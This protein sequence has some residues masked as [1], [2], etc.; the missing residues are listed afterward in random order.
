MANDRHYMVMDTE[1][2]GLYP[3]KGHE[4]VQLC[5]TAVNCYTLE[6]H[7][8]G[9]FS[10]LIKPQN[11]DKAD[12]KAIEV[13]GKDLWDRAQKEGLEPK[14]AYDRFLKW[15][16]NINVK[17]SFWEKPMFVGFNLKFDVPFINFMLKKNGLYPEDE[18]KLP[19]SVNYL[20]LYHILYV[21]CETDPDVKNFKLD[22]FLQLLGLS[23]AS[24]NHDAVEDV[25]L[26]ADV[27]I[28]TLKFFRKLRGRI[29]FNKTIE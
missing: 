29:S 20:D 26:T 21:L 24:E 9:S 22:T 25:Q 19:W 1:T 28:R 23:R 17:K 7:P 11:P 8:A 3:E 27:L 6:K 16:A 13:I 15:C 14:V 12:P 4:I 5:A 2:S 10:V 18:I